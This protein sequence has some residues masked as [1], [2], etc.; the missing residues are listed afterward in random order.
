MSKGQARIRLN[1]FISTLVQTS[2]PL[3]TK[4][5]T[6]PHSE[7]L[8]QL[9]PKMDATTIAIKAVHPSK[10]KTQQFQFSPFAD[11]QQPTR[12]L[13]SRGGQ[14]CPSCFAHIH[15][16]NHCQ[17]DTDKH[18]ARGFT[19]SIEPRGPSVTVFSVRFFERS[20]HVRYARMLENCSFGKN[21]SKHARAHTAHFELEK[22]NASIWPGP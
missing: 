12:P 15:V 21:C 3:T 22:I 5:C 9:S 7:E 10:A 16:M 18:T 19:A 4:L 17:G 20:K 14:P 6:P 2:Y 13:P 8:A 1:S 11:S